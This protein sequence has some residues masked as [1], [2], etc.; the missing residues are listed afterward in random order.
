MFVRAAHLAG[1]QLTRPKYA[2]AVQQIPSI[3]LAGLYGGHFASGKTDYA[4]LLRPIVYH[5]DC[6]CYRNTGTVSSGKA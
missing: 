3:E 2:A 4:D 1:A 6:T 5:K